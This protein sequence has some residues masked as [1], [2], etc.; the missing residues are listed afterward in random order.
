[1]IRKRTKCWEVFIHINLFSTLGCLMHEGWSH[2]SLDLQI[3]AI[4]N[5]QWSCFFDSIKTKLYIISNAFMINFIHN[6]HIDWDYW[7]LH[8]SKRFI[9]SGW[10]RPARY[11]PNDLTHWIKAQCVSYLKNMWFSDKSNIGHESTTTMTVK[12]QLRVIGLFLWNPIL[13][14]SFICQSMPTTNLL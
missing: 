7:Y 4:H 8:L 5:L 13:V 2:I 1:M 3:Y 10:K 9:I 14:K 6:I 12:M 11:D